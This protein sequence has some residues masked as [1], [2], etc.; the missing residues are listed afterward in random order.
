MIIEQS[1]II[2]APM[3]YVMTIMND[4]AA[5]PAWATV[6][7]AVY[8]IRGSGPGLSYDWQFTFDDLT[9]SGHSKVIEQTEDTLITETT[10]DVASI[11]TIRLT[12]VAKNTLVRVVVEYIPFSAFV[13]VLADVVIQRYATPA[14]AEENMNRFKQLVEKQ[15]KLLEEYA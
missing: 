10:G 8:N 13:E 3:K 6:D 1:A 2:E 5:I 12:P 9:F 7:G 14:V 15:V 4:V 11:W